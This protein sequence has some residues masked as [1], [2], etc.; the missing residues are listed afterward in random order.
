MAGEKT[1]KATPKR[2][3][4][5]RKKGN[6]FTSREVVT[7]STLLTVFFAMKLL[8][9]SALGIL[10]QTVSRYFLLGSGQSGLTS[11]DV[12]AFFVDCCLTFC[13]TALPL[14]L[15]AALTA[16]IITMAQ[17]KMLFSAKAFQ[18]K[19]ERI[20]PL[21]G[22]KRMFSL[23]SLVELTKSLIKISVLLYL[24]YTVMKAEL[25]MLPR[26]M[27]MT[28]M[29]AMS[30]TGQIIFSIVLKAGLIFAFLAAA[31]YFYQWWEYEKNLRMSKQEIKDE[32]KQ[33]E[34]DPQVKG[35]IRSLQQQRARRRMMQNVPNAD[36]VIR[37]PTH[38]AVAILY[39][40]NKHRAPVVV[41]KGVDAVALRIVKVAEENGVY[42]T[43]DKPLARGLY[44]NV[45]IDREIPENYYQA[46]AQVLAFVYSLKK[47]DLK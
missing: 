16:V 36:V 25:P 37:N 2:K 40:Q 7:I 24:I 22:F 23:R 17:T 41:A 15:T 18:F 10:E 30:R 14:L 6:V 46:I 45:E 43:E 9:P 33:T 31:D 3:Q 8:L 27:D 11:E 28:P 19:A 29:A 13:R 38:Y 21:K 42:V 39:D 1:E 47:K 12:A 44:E 4:D 32:Y 20:S 5:E 26:L 34:G 35:R